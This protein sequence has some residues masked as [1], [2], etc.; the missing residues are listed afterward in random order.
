[1]ALMER[2]SLLFYDTVISGTWGDGRQGRG[3]GKL[4]FFWANRKPAH[5]HEGGDT[6]ESRNLKETRFISCREWMR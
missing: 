1:M 2:E 3:R 4:V 6:G 5:H